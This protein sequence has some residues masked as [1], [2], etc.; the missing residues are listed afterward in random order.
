MARRATTASRNDGATSGGSATFHA[1]SQETTA[2]GPSA[3]VRPMEK[4]GDGDK[5]GDHG[6]DTTEGAEQATLSRC[7][8]RTA[9]DEAGNDGFGTWR[10]E[11]SRKERRRAAVPRPSTQPVQENPGGRPSARV[12]P[13]EKNGSGGKAG[14]RDDETWHDAREDWWE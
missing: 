6:V 10:P 2:A 14:N 5:A 3:R 8:E 12:R 9:M 13:R 11:S 7:G 4:G 1:S